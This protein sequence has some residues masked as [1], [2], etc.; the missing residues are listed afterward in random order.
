MLKLTRCALGCPLGWPQAALFVIG[1]LGVGCAGQAPESA[2]PHSEPPEGT[3]PSAPTHAPSA[4]QSDTFELRLEVGE[5]QVGEPASATLVLH[6]T[7]P[8]KCNDKYPYRFQPHPTAGLTFPDEPP[9]DGGSV[10][11]PDEVRL[12]VPF[13]ATEVGEHRLAGVL[14]FSVCT[15]D[16]CLIERRE[17]SA[18]VRAR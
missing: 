7:A 2:A 12:T 15:A 8:Y 17:L 18:V 11:S 10:V 13:T 3:A 5:A 14:S 16:R 9:S 6:G 1:F 4:L